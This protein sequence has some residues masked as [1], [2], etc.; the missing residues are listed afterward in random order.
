MTSELHKVQRPMKDLVKWTAI[1]SLNLNSLLSLMR[2][3]TGCIRLRLSL[4]Q[5][6]DWSMKRIKKMKEKDIRL[7]LLFCMF[8]ALA[9]DILCVLF[10]LGILQSR[11]VL[12]VISAL[13]ILLHTALALFGFVQKRTVVVWVSLL[14]LIGYTG[15]FI[16]YNLEW[17]KGLISL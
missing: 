12:N 11:W 5:P 16:Y 7:A 2:R 4:Q 9:A 14:L 6:W 1:L 15:N 3:R 10:L 17:L 13:A 8:T